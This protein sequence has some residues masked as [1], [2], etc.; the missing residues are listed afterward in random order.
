LCAQA[1]DREQALPVLLLSL[2]F[3]FNLA[4]GFSLI[5]PA[6]SF[7][8]PKRPCPFLNLIFPFI[9]GNTREQSRT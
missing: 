3:G 1:S 7:F 9:A 2:N 5:T 4:Q 8:M 6:V